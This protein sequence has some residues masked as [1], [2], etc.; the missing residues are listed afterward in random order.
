MELTDKQVEHVVDSV[1]IRFG[2]TGF[3]SAHRPA[4]RDNLL[5]IQLRGHPSCEFEME[6]NASEDDIRRKA[7]EIFE[8]SEKAN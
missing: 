1:A 7:E 6:S 8:R 4:N 5:V 2:I 3:V